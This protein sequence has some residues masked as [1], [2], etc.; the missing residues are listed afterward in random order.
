MSHI[1]QFIFRQQSL[2]KGPLPQAGVPNE[3]RWL[4]LDNL[5]EAPMSEEKAYHKIVHTQQ[6]GRSNQA[7]SDGIK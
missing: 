1:Q 2:R 4:A 3:R 6:R 7:A 5:V